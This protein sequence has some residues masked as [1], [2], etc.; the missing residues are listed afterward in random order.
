MGG[1]EWAKG[2]SN[3]LRTRKNL[4]RDGT[5]S[6]T[7]K[8]QMHLM[9]RTMNL[10]HL[11]DDIEINEELGKIIDRLTVMNLQD[12]QDGLIKSYENTLNGIPQN[13]F[14]IN[15]PEEDAFE[16]SRRIEAIDMILS[17][18]V[19]GHKNYDFDAVEWWDEND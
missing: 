4:T 17:L 10:E 6:L 9:G 1:K 5:V 7:R 8:V 11:L 18:M 16:I 19:A 12:M 3:V 13:A 15:D 14:V 2:A